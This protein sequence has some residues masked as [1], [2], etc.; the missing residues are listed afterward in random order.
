MGNT[1]Y[2]QLSGVLSAPVTLAAAM[3][4]W[5]GAV[6]AAVLGGYPAMFW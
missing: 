6:L 1:H 4:P 3:A 5:I 2:G